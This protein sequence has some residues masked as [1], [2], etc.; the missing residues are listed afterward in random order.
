MQPLRFAFGLTLAVVLI[1]GCNEGSSVKTQ[2]LTEGNSGDH[3]HEGHDGH[4]H[5]EHDG[6][7]SES[8]KTLAAGVAQLTELRD[9]I[10]TAMDADDLKKADGPVHQVGHLLEQIGDLAGEAGLN[11]TEEKDVKAAITTLFESFASLDKTIHGKSD[12]KSW[13]DV[14]SD[15]DQAISALQNI[16]SEATPQTES[17]ETKE[18]E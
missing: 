3:S 13:K 7:G 18:E 1:A 15:I 9:A 14:S 11:E 8:P 16:S 17:D 5:H 10:A 4:D 12:G 2:E 6:H